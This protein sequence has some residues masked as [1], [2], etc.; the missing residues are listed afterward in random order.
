[1]WAQDSWEQ[2]STGLTGR[3]WQSESSWVAPWRVRA[4]GIKACRPGPYNAQC[5]TCSHLPTATS[6]G[7][8]FPR[9]HVGTEGGEE[10]KS[11]QGTDYLSWACAFHAPTNLRGWCSPFLHVSGWG[12]DIGTLPKSP[13]VRGRAGLAVDAPHCSLRV[14]PWGTPSQGWLSIEEEVVQDGGGGSVSKG[15]AQGTGPK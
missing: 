11:S 10:R 3:G 15:A 4:W 13:L 9:I 7:V 6:E 2:G 5:N 14:P 8:S 12:S 1:M